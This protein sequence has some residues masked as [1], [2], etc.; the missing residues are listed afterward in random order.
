MSVVERLRDRLAA[1]PLQ[2]RVVPFVVFLLLGLSQGA[3]GDSSRFWGYL[4]KTVVGVWLLWLTWPLVVEMRWKLSWEA[5]VAGVAVLVIWVGLE[6][7]YPKLGSEPKPWNPFASFADAPALAWFFVG[8]R[9]I[10][11]T[12][13]VPPLEEVFF[14]S[15]VYRYV[16]KADFHL[17]AVGTWHAVAFFVTSALFAI[18]HREWLPGLL[19]GFIYQGLVC[20][21]GRLGD[22]MT[23]HAITNFLLGL[24]VVWKGAWQFW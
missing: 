22:A 21:K 4:F 18:E 1:S 20:W 8:M 2:A 24:W 6:G 5:V 12:L 16:I 13:V 9:I 11:S 14:R 17:I 23:A 7:F 3:L 19:C 15:F 10:G